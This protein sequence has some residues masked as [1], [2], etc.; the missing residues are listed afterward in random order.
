MARQAALAPARIRPITPRKTPPA[1]LD[2]EQLRLAASFQAKHYAFIQQVLGTS[3][4]AAT[5]AARDIAPILMLTQRLPRDFTPR[6]Q[7]TGA[8]MGRIMADFSGRE[9]F[10]KNNYAEAVALG[11]LHQKVAE[12]TRGGLKWNPRERLPMNA[13]SFAFVLYTFAWWPIEAMIARKLVEPGK[14]RKE[15]DAWLHYWSVLGH[16]MGVDRELLP[17]SYTLAKERVELLRQ[18]QYVPVG[19]PRPEGIP[20][21]LGGQ[22]RFIATMLVSKPGGAPPGKS[23]LEKLYGFGAQALFGMILLSPGL[24]EALGLEKDGTTQLIRFAQRE[25]A[26]N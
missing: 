23:A 5:F 26:S 13:Q 4:L 11:E 19:A 25:T 1:W 2:F 15:L 18:A 14:D 12:A 3:S 8:L 22:V 17:L 9:G 21:L 6:M 20:I 10:L 7:E 16:G 24:N